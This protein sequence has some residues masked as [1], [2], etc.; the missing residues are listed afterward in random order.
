[1]Y[2]NMRVVRPKL[3]VLSARVMVFLFVPPARK[4]GGIVV[5]I[6]ATV[7][8]VYPIFSLLAHLAFYLIAS[9]IG[10]LCWCQQWLINIKNVF[11]ASRVP[12]KITCHTQSLCFFSWSET[13][14]S[15]NADLCAATVKHLDQIRELQFSSMRL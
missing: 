15:V 11:A 12:S 1:M 8:K 2:Y 5:Q 6:I 14:L 7:S 10:S 4:A 9:Y 3:V 13:Y